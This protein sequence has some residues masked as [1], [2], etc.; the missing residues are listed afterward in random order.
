MTGMA[1]RQCR[2]AL[3]SRDSPPRPRAR[4]RPLHL[5]PGC[6]RAENPPRQGLGAR[7]GEGERKPRK[8]RERGARALRLAGRD[9][10]GVPE[11]SVERGRGAVAVPDRDVDD[12]LPA[13][14]VE[15]GAGDAAPAH[16]LPETD[17][18]DIG[19]HP[20]E[21]SL[22]AGGEPRRMGEVEVPLEVRLYVVHRV[23]EALY[24]AHRVTILPRREH[25]ATRQ[26][27][28]P[29]VQGANNESF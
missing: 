1:R 22:G 15:R 20:P 27:D 14:Q 9:P 2:A 12:P 10:E 25:G 17:A 28:S 24:P 19:E 8:D 26:R 23:V 18:G 13:G 16:V 5:H 29:R 11:R 21:L 7:D 4:G 6:E 3:G